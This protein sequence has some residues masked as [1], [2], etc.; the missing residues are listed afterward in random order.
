VDFILS[1]DM[2]IFSVGKNEIRNLLEKESQLKSELK[3]LAKES[4]NPNVQN[5]KTIMLKNEMIK[6]QNKIKILS[7]K[8]GP[9]DGDVA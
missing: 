5:F 3:K 7:F 2:S 4:T 9:D 1:E 6:I 8:N